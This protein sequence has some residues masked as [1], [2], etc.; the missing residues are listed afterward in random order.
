MIRTNFQYL[1]YRKNVA[2]IILNNKNQIL[3]VQ[4]NPLNKKSYIV[5]R[6]REKYLNYWQLPQG[7]I[8]QHESLEAAAHREAVEETGL[9]NLRLLKISDQTNTYNFTPSW[10]RLFDSEYRFRGQRQN[11]VYLKSEHDQPVKIDNDEA[12]NYR[13]VDISHL[14]NEVHEER[15]PLAKIVQ[16]DLT[17]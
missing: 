13:W 10:K 15:V 14:V 16:E 3:I 2:C 8:D 9:H 6:D 17:R 11:V 7:G 12:I 5:K 4:R 1:E